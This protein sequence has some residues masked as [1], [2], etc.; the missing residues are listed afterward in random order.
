MIQ[1]GAQSAGSGPPPGSCQ[2]GKEG[3]DRCH[4]GQVI[5]A[6]W[7]LVSSEQPKWRDTVIHTTLVSS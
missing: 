6:V 5:S 2:G 1:Q 4:L 7:V 3:W